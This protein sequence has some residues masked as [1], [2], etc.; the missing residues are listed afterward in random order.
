MN[1]SESKYFNTAVLMD[2]ALLL[3]LERKDIQYITVKEICEK[4]G[5]NRTTFYL[6]YDS[7][8]DLLGETVNYVT[9]RLVDAY[10][11]EP[12]SFIGKIENAKLSELV[13][14]NS[15]FLHPYLEFVKANKSVF[16]AV[17]KNPQ[18]M[19]AESQYSN[20]KK[21]ILE[22]V[23]KRFNIPIAEQKY[24]INYYMSGFMAIILQWVGED[25]KDSVEFIENVIINCVR[26][27]NGEQNKKF[28]EK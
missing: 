6:H 3:L 20:I 26:P 18:C 16:R 7:I 5:V 11:T 27:H 17:A 21:Y 14:V 25:C 12:A 24:W 22:P 2:E 28:G 19:R 1:K 9:Q 8:S 13:F 10:E 4:A 23:M 15:T